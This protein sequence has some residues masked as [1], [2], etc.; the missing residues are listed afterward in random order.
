MRHAHSPY[1]PPEPGAANPDNRE[2]ER[3]LDE[4]GRADARAMGEALRILAIAIGRVRSSPSYRALETVRYL[5]LPAPPPSEELSDAG[6]A[7]SGLAD[8]QRAA[9]L[10]EK[11]AAPPQIANGMFVT[12][13]PNIRAAFG[14][15]APDI[16]D[17]E[18]LVFRPASS[19]S[20]VLLARVRIR[21]WPQWAATLPAP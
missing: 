14:E 10:R 19:G 2:R 16:A 8:E 1:A 11:A 17:G 21:E 4:I 7:M 20:A 13:L 18:T 9:W 5:G 6:Q 12:H 15:F 3:Q